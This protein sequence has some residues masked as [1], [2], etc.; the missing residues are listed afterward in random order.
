MDKQYILSIEELCFSLAYCGYEEMAAGMLKGNLGDISEE[1]MELVF[2]TSARSLHTKG[3]LLQLNQ[4]DIENSFVDDF[5]GILDDLASSHYFLRCFN[6]TEYGQFVLT[7]HKGRKGYV[8]HLVSNEIVHVLNYLERDLLA[9]EIIGFFNPPFKNKNEIT[10]TLSEAQFQKLMEE[11]QS[12]ND[13]RQL[14]AEIENN[15]LIVDKFIQDYHENNGN[16]V[17]M[18]I[19]HTEENT[20]PAFSEVYLLLITNERVWMMHNSNIDKEQEPIIT[21]KTIDEQEW[22]V[23][24]NRLIDSVKEF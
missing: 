1:S 10:F 8:Y 13:H 3:I 14:L 2:Q 6:E 16:I 18:S 17:N 11:L 9:N 24:I 12:K 19:I 22:K 4:D 5:K 21:I 23:I 20:L 7:V 15:Q